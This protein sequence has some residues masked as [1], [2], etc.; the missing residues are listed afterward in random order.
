MIADTIEKLFKKIKIWFETDIPTRR[1]TIDTPGRLWYTDSV[2]WGEDFKMEPLRK[3]TDRQGL[4]AEYV[5]RFK[6]DMPKP[7]KGI[8]ALKLEIS[9]LYSFNKG[10]V[11]RYK[12]RMQYYKDDL[13]QKKYRNMFCVWQSFAQFKKFKEYLDT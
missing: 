5:A 1:L 8:S 6:E 4:N 11:Q 10:W 13:S 9:Q 3:A 7:R 2:G 12:S